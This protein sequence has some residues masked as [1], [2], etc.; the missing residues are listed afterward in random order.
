MRTVTHQ[1]NRSRQRGMTL[2][3][4]GVMSLGLA[5][6]QS[7]H[8]P[9]CRSEAPPPRRAETNIDPG[10][11]RADNGLPPGLLHGGPRLRAPARRRG[12]GERRRN[13]HAVPRGL[14]QVVP[15]QRAPRA[16]LRSLPRA[17]QPARGNPR[18]GAGADLQLQEGRRSGGPGRGLLE[19]PRAEP[20]RARR[21]VADLQARPLR[22][23]LRRLP[24]RPLQRARSARPPPAR[25][26]RP[27]SR[28]APRPRSFPTTRPK[29]PRRTCLRSAAPRTTW[30]PWPRTSA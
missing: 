12:D 24:P 9:T 7:S 4:L 22:R 6:C 5:S 13:L 27:P 29:R 14:R 28:P 3:L 17:G 21:P 1:T 2:V 25:R 23:D 19:V 16:E 20:V 18:Q 10:W 11:P 30:A 15:R 8:N 26:R